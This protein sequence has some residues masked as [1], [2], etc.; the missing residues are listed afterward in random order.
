MAEIID[1]QKHR[2]TCENCVYW[3]P[4]IKDGKIILRDSSCGYPGGWTARITG[5]YPYENLECNEF[6]SKRRY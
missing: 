1:L 3:K 6:K 4:P 2:R 5:R